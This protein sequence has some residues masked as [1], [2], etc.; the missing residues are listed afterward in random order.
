MTDN[1]LSTTLLG[2]F[3]YSDDFCNVASKIISKDMFNNPIVGNAVLAIKIYYDR[4]NS[5]PDKNILID[6]IK[7]RLIG[8]P[9]FGLGEEAANDV[10]NLLNTVS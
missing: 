10:I 7:T 3:L 2:L 6:F 4:Y 1:K 8:S 9:K 5:R